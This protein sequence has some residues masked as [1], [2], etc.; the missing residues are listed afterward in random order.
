MTHEQ[1]QGNKKTFFYNLFN[2]DSEHSCLLNLGDMRTISS[3]NNILSGQEFIITQ[4]TAVLH[5][6][7][8]ASPKEPAYHTHTLKNI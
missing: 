8:T 3:F 6:S 1:G 2:H 5:I 4:Q 7:L